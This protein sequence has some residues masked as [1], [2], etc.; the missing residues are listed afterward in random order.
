[1]LERRPS[2]GETALSPSSSLDSPTGALKSPEGSKCAVL[3]PKMRPPARAVSAPS[4]TAM[5]PIDDHM[6]DSSLSLPQC[7]RDRHRH[8]PPTHP[9]ED[10]TPR[11]LE[12]HA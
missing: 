11:G 1:M 9:L 3:Q 6:G 8:K 7:R 5:F 12:P 4:S 10:G 2:E